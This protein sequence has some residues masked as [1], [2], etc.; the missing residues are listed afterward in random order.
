MKL[1][2]AKQ[3]HYDSGP[4]MTPLVDVVM[5]ILIFLMLA[6]SFGAS[7]HYMMSTVPLHENGGGDVKDP[8]PQMTDYR[9]SV[10]GHENQFVA[11]AGEAT[12]TTGEELTS[13]LTATKNSMERLGTP[14]DK[15][16][17]IIEPGSTVEY[18]YLLLV[19]QSALDAQF[20]KVAF[21]QMH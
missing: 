21:G 15:I 10:D 19:Y 5:V 17:V 1:K 6:G 14:V 2:G 9:I 18:K 4:N 3:V 20:T 7:E 8:I 12:C 13:M 11:R 16:Q